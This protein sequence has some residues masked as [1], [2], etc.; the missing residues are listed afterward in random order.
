[1]ALMNQY[2][3]ENK[4]EAEIKKQDDLFPLEGFTAQHRNAYVSMQQCAEHVEYH[5]PNQHTH[6]GYL[7]EGIQCP[8]PSLQA[9]MASICTDSRLQG[10]HNNFEATAT[11]PLPY[12][13]VIKKWAA[14]TR[15]LVAQILALKEIVLRLLTQLAR[16]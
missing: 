9:A 12:D 6:M 5:L 8:D 10:M 4:W 7:L 16:N 14:S 15:C 3:G 11:H 2:T 13:P 1:M